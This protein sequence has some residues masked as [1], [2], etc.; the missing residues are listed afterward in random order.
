MSEE[1]TS[2]SQSPNDSG[3]SSSPGNSLFSIDFTPQLLLMSVLGL[4]GLLLVCVFG[5][6]LV[7]P[8]GWTDEPDDGVNVEVIESEGEGLNTSADGSDAIVIFDGGTPLSIDLDPP[9]SLELD[10]KTIP[11]K[12]QFVT[13]AGSWDPDIADGRVAEWVF[14]TIVNPVFGLSGSEEN[15]LL[16]Q[17]LVPG[18][19]IKINYNSGDDREFLVSGREFVSISDSEL[20]AQNRPGV[21]LLWLGGN[22]PDNRLVVYGEYT[23]PESTA[24]QIEDDRIASPQEPVVFGNLA[25]T[26]NQFQLGGANTIA[27]PGFSIFLVDFVIDNQGNNRIDSGLLRISLK[28]QQGNQYSMNSAA[29][30][31]GTFPALSGFIEPG[32]QKQATAAFQI[33]SGL[34]GNLLEWKMSRVD[35]PGEISVGIP[36]GGNDAMNAAVTLTAADVSE[37]GATIIVSGSVTNGGSQ[38]F[39]VNASDVSLTENGTVFLVFSTTPGFPW[40]VPPGQVVNFSLSFQRPAGSSATFTLLGDSFELNGIR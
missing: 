39:L 8:L 16:L 37:D 5:V 19:K 23:L 40:S 1:E 27:P 15:E 12:A 18:D 4:L 26:V 28:D 17:K 29:A 6:L 13:E 20:F 34:S 21:T 14:G 31:S 30:A 3:S 22:S 11:I 38:S 36:F 10:G 2:T 24:S 7:D 35:I 33:P 25:I 9:S 32:S